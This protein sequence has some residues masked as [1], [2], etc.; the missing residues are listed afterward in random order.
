MEFKVGHCSIDDDFGFDTISTRDN[1]AK[2][3]RVSKTA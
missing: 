2:E 3:E 1:K